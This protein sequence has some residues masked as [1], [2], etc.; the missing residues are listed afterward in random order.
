[1]NFTPRCR[2][3][4]TFFAAIRL[5]VQSTTTST[6]P[7][8]SS[9]S[10]AT[11]RPACCMPSDAAGV[12]ANRRSSFRMTVAA[13]QSW[14]TSAMPATDMSGCLPTAAA[15]RLPM[16]PYP[17][18]PTRMCV[19]GMGILPQPVGVQ[20][21]CVLACQL[22]RWSAAVAAGGLRPQR[23][24]RWAAHPG[25]APRRPRSISPFTRRDVSSP[26]AARRR[27]SP[28][29]ATSARGLG[30]G[31]AV[32]QLEHLLEPPVA[33][34]PPQRPHAF[35][36]DLVGC[37]LLPEQRHDLVDELVERQVAL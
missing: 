23:V 33:L 28:P 32:D 31:V 5:G 12:A 37:R 8:R 29:G 3:S 35:D 30:D 25:S 19:V 4:S 14:K 15:T 9:R 1:M 2:Y 36:E 13:R 6:W 16:T 20:L 11:V 21:V 24:G 27:T 7:S 18:T 26:W 10:P 22:V 17:T 34:G